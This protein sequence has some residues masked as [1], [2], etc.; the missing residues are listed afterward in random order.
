MSVYTGLNM[1]GEY[2]GKAGKQVK[3]E[4]NADKRHFV[5]RFIAF[6]HLFS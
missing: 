5:R 1:T 3:M 4:S 2:G 6:A